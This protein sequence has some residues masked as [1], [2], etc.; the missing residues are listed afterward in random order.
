MDRPAI[1]STENP[2][3]DRQRIVAPA[4]NGG[5]APELRRVADA[6][7]GS[8]P[9]MAGYAW[10]VLQRRW[11][12]VGVVALAAVL[13]TTYLFLAPRVYQTAGII[14]IE[15]KKTMLGGI[16][17]PATPAGERSPAE[18]DIEVL[19]SRTVIG[20]VVDELHLDIEAR[21]RTFPVIGRAVARLYKGHTP[22]PPRLPRLP[23]LARYA[24]GGE[25][26]IVPRLEVAEDLLD[27]PLL[28]T[29]L[30]GGRYRL[31]GRDG[32]PVLDGSIGTTAS[33]AD[34]RVELTV[35][36]LV[37][38]PGTEFWVVKRA[39]E[40]VIDRIQ[41]QLRVQEKGKGSGILAVELEGS[42]AP[43]TAAIVNAVSAA[44]LRQKVERRSAE[45]AEKLRFVELQLPRVKVNLDRAEAALNGFRNANATVDLTAETKG[46]LD[47][48]AELAKELFE[49][50]QK[51][52]ELLRALNEQH[53][54]VVVLSDRI[55]LVKA[56][57]VAL[58][59]RMRELPT[60]ESSAARL[61]SE[62]RD[63]K[64]LY[65]MLANKAQEL[66]VA[67]SVT[68]G[69]ARVV[70]RAHSPLRPASPKTEAVVV[71][72]LLLGL[73]GGVAMAL[74]R[75]AVRHNAEDA[76]EIEAATGI[77]VYVTVPHSDAQ[78]A[79]TRA[80]RRRE[81]ATTHLLSAAGPAD[82]AV[83]AMRSLR[84]S[85]QFALVEAR[86]N[87]VAMTGPAPGV[88][89]SFVALNLAHVLAAAGKR[90]LLVDA[91]LRRG[92]LH[93]HFGFERHPGVSDVVS[94]ALKL[95]DALHIMEDGRLSLLASGRIPP[96]P[97]EL[98]SSHQFES[99][100]TDASSR[101]D[102]VIVDTPPLLAVSDSLLVAR[103]AGVNFLV[104]RAGAHSVRE[105]ALAV[106]QF[107]L[108]GIKLHGAVLN[109]VHALKGRYG[110][111]GRYVKYEYASAKSA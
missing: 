28:L 110:K 106:K 91:D 19:R 83:E 35:S 25:Q 32:A 52:S 72:T 86:N 66:R 59:T 31:V 37:A 41:T 62:T 88:G 46:M 1:L 74:L 22:A 10:I 38:R 16:D 82:A 79:L 63:A 57:Q 29:V 105:I 85:L 65:E 49:L 7:R 67:K 93:Q 45:A 55:A 14:Q 108:N 75:G 53:P 34:D 15:P 18:G 109:D 27:V 99:L 76:E 96:N 80:A 61:F 95:E 30:E 100:L 69:D 40:D 54:S 42:D 78:A 4:P 73:S 71:L 39:R 101:Y 87:V 23:Q 43:R 70:D 92:C 5:I 44:Y 48:H 11:T 6:Q 97:A 3:R 56:E 58:A 51:R 24:W 64:A 104:L 107:A 90:V 84:T 81:G 9:T 21:P 8:E 77:P 103:F 68:L 13:G 98:L 2:A 94:G 36:D 26:I 89:K 111:S 102:F 12:V 33:A 20:A 47:R 50:E 60:R 17:D